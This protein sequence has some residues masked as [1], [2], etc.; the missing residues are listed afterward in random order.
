MKFR[1]LTEELIRYNDMKAAIS[2]LKEQIETLELEATSIKATDY[3][4]D[5]VSGGGDNIKEANLVENIAKREQM[6]RDLKITE[7]NVKSIEIALNG[8]TESERTILTRMYI[9]REHRA[10]ERIMDEMSIEQSQL[11]RLKDKA[12]LHYGVRKYGNI[13]L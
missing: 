7:K 9:N 10:A 13:S 5:V 3:S 4:R 1:F 11:Y 12:L 8:I 6:E 2:S